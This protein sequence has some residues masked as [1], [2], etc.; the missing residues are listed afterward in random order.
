[1]AVETCAAGIQGLTVRSVLCLANG[2]LMKTR[3]EM[4]Y[5]FMLAL[6]SNMDMTANRVSYEDA[7][8]VILQQAQAL[9]DAYLEIV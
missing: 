7:A 8:V 4:I 1:M 3:T 2:V 6:A 5:D 9:A